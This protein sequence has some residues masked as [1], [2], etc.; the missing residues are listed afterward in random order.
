M[1]NSDSL[2]CHPLGHW[3]PEWSARTAPMTWADIASGRR[4]LAARDQMKRLVVDPRLARGASKQSSGQIA[5]PSALT[6]DP[7]CRAPLCVACAGDA[8]T[9]RALFVI[10]VRKWIKCLKVCGE[11]LGIIA[12]AWEGLQAVVTGLSGKGS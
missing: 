5:N 6:A 1:R 11:V 7:E 9:R 2:P 4:K 12:P 3:S 10:V 8:L